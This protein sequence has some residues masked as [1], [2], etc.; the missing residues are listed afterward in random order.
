MDYLVKYYTLPDGIEIPPY[1]EWDETM[2]PYAVMNVSVTGLG[3]TYTAVKI[4]AS[5]VP[6][7]TTIKWG[8]RALVSKQDGYVICYR[9]ASDSGTEFWRDTNND[10]AIT[11]GE[12]KLLTVHRANYDIQEYTEPDPDIPVVAVEVHPASFMAGLRMGQ[13]I[14]GIRG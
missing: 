14:R 3:G 7:Y 1:P 8:T 11:A 10:F 12:A 2:Y 4:Y 5:N 13:I 6:L 9:W